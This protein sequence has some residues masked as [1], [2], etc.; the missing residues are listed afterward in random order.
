VTPLTCPQ[1]AGQLYPYLDGAMT[2]ESRAVLEAHLD[3][4]PS[5]ADRLAFSRALEATVRRRLREEPVPPG[6]RARV[7]QALARS[8][9]AARDPE[10][11]LYLDIHHHI[12]G[13][14][15]PGILRAHKRDL[16]VQGRYDV[17]YLQYWYDEG[18]G[19]VF[20]LIEAP[21]KEAAA[22]VHR[23]AHGFVAD[24]IVQVKEGR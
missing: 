14:T 7:R 10:R 15:A 13:L 22:L 23:E 8:A 19:K 12:P 21:S 16:E 6:L 20:C 11:S 3:G 2:G 24:E 1:A 4:C 18:T 17:K 5:C 9:A